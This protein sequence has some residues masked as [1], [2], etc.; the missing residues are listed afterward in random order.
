MAEDLIANVDG[1]LDTSVLLQT[2]H[3][4]SPFFFWARYAALS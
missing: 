2:G 4:M 3:A 1:I